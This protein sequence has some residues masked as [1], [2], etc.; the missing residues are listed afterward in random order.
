MTVQTR[1]IAALVCAITLAGLGISLYEVGKSDG[2]HQRDIEAK[3]ENEAVAVAALATQTKQ[4]EQLIKAINVRTDK[5]QSNHAD[6]VRADTERN[7]VRLTFGSIGSGL[8]LP[9]ATYT[10]DQAAE[11]KLL[12]AIGIAVDKFAEGVERIAIEADG[13]A[14]DSLTYQHG[15]PK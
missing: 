7:R 15:W 1:I 5:T 4:S 11:R 6:S 3:A 12:D 8:Q 14:A 9:A 10:D 13:H 2:Y